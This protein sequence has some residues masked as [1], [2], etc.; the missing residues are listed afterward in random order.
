M[1]SS[2]IASQ[3]IEV[4][5]SQVERSNSYLSDTS[6]PRG[7]APSAKM[8]PKRF[9]VCYEPLMIILE[10]TE[11]QPGL[12]NPQAKPSFG[13]TK[14]PDLLDLD[15]LDKSQALEAKKLHHYQM[16]I[17]KELLLESSRERAVEQVIK[18][19]EKA[20]TEQMLQVYQSPENLDAADQLRHLV[21]KMVRKSRRDA[22]DIKSEGADARKEAVMKP[23]EHGRPKGIMSSMNDQGDGDEKAPLLMDEEK[24]D[25][26]NYDVGQTDAKPKVPRHPEKPFES[27][28][29]SLSQSQAYSLTVSAITATSSAFYKIV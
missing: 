11:P 4:D 23:V 18:H 27:S 2:P 16:A 5:L 28:A 17:P 15:D 3:I 22:T 25:I 26:E 7:R 14:S 6:E 20:H 8:V 1:E 24:M 13:P 21:G 29:R 9:V 12:A 19:L 10:Y